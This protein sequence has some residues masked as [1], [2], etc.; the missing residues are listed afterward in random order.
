MANAT[1]PRASH[2]LEHI[3]TARWIASMA[4]V[5]PVPRVGHPSQAAGGG[6][7]GPSRPRCLSA[8]RSPVAFT[9]FS[10]A[11]PPGV[12][13]VLADQRLAGAVLMLLPLPAAA[14][15]AERMLWLRQT[16]LARLRTS[17]P[18]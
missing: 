11:A 6:G 10:L 17:P 12:A 16:A 9:W 7:P 8:A 15:L 1:S 3:A 5:D 18:L 2:Q 13:D 14:V 4:G